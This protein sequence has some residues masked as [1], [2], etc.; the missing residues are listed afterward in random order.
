MKAC[1][2]KSLWNNPMADTHLFS[3]DPITLEA[4]LARREARA[5]RQ[6]ALLKA[7][8]AP[9]ICLCA[10]MPGAVKQNEAARRIV[11]AGAQALQ[12]SLL[13]RGY[14]ILHEEAPEAATGPERL[15]CINVPPEVLK[16]LCV[17]VE[18]THPLGRLFDLDVIGPAG[19]LSRAA[20]GHPPR[21][22][23]VCGNPAVI[24]AGRAL[25]PL[26]EV[27][28]AVTRIL[29]DANGD[30]GAFPAL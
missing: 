8:A 26:E 18:E 14:F 21:R 10:N 6:Q 30:T 17:E 22:C 5:T 1:S 15:Y 12:S 16:A 20:L 2:S 11:A 7:Y 4:L 19:Q 23:L 27:Q 9:V 25:H 3:G 29:E 13:A 24:C 28:A